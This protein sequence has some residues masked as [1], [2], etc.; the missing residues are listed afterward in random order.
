MQVLEAS[1]SLNLQNVLLGD[2]GQLQLVVFDL[3]VRSFLLTKNP[4]DKLKVELR[5]Y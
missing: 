5:V 1:G 4:F 2:G 3:N